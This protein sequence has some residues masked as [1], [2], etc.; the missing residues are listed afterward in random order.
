MTETLV[1]FNGVSFSYRN[2][3]V[4][5]NFQFQLTE[6]QL[7]ALIGVNGS[8]KSTLLKLI[9]GL[10]KPQEGEVKVLGHKAGAFPT[11][12][13][14]GS[15]LQDIDFPGSER[16]EEILHFV[17]D[18]YP[19]SESVSTLIQDFQ[20]ADFHRKACSQLSGGMRRRL[21]LACAFAGRPEVVLLDEPT[22]GLDVE[23]RQHLIKNL[24]NYQKKYGTLVL[25][26]S[27]HPEEIV[28]W[29]DEFLHLKNKTV[30]KLSIENMQQSARLRKVHFEVR[31]EYP[32]PKAK[33]IDRHG[34][35]V[36]IIT[37]D[38]DQYV[39]SLVQQ[40]IPFQ[41]LR[42][43]KLSVDELLGDFL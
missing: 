23:S 8:G 31:G 18:Q 6:P 7:I 19:A 34:D 37:E 27:H 15:A 33:R 20:L 32:L 9:L 35:Q 38:S 36:E 22:T 43:D 16:V 13:Q 42:I 5:R 11:K 17:C 2:Q 14:V 29:V 39:Q 1:E 41:N 26:I 21:A 3:K 4:L 40:K 30:E 28:P 12:F 24:K 25:M 10:L